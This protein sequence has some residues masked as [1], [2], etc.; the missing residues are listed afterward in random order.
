M[1]SNLIKTFPFFEAANIE[2][3]SLHQSYFL[4]FLKVLIKTLSIEKKPVNERHINGDPFLAS[5]KIQPFI[6]IKQTFCEVF[7]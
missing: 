5:A 3:F 2:P 7:F 1:N 6:F 4:F